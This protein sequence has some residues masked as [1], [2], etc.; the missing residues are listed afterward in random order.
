MK[1]QEKNNNQ[2]K[3]TYKKPELTPLGDIRDVTM[4]SSF[5][6]ADSGG[7]QTESGTQP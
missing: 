6:L 3:A 5:A 7:G 1:D 2:K 4:G